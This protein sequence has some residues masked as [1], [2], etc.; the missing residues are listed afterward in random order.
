MVYQIV[1]FRLRSTFSSQGLSEVEVRPHSDS[2]IR[3]MRTQTPFQ[4]GH[5]FFDLGPNHH[6]AVGV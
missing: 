3:Q 2:P 4:G 6:A 1:R 5:W